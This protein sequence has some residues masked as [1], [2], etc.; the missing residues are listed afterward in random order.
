MANSYQ[1]IKNG[2]AE[3]TILA[4]KYPSFLEGD[5]DEIVEVIP[6]EPKQKPVREPKPVVL[7]PVDFKV[8][9]TS[10]E[11]LAISNARETDLFINDFMSILDDVRLN[12]IDLGSS[13]VI[14]F[15]DHLVTES[16]ITSERKLEITAS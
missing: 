9:F 2:E 15:L 4:G 5:Y 12:K 11:R 1:L 16:I 14:E 3:N 6:P 7:S 8:R 10:S 13:F